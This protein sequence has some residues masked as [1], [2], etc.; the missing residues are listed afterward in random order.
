MSG[1]TPGPWIPVK[2]TIPG[3]EFW[4]A[5]HR[6]GDLSQKG[7][8][9]EANAR[10]IAAAP[11]LLEAAQKHLEWIDKERAGPQYPE[12]VSRDNGGDAI[13][14][15]WWGEQLDLCRDTEDF[16]RSAIAKAT[17]EK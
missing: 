15:A 10:L 1:H 14:R 3:H 16:C 6:G 13:W 2:M 12:G 8:E 7:P 9:A 11:E 4:V 17:G 5:Q